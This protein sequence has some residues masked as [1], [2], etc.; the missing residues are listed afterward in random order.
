MKKGSV[1][2]SNIKNEEVSTFRKTYKSLLDDLR[3]DVM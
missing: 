3:F 2:Q 1:R